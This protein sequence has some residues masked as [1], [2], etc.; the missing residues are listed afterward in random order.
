MAQK[1]YSS[2][3]DWARKVIYCELC[4]KMKLDNT[5]K[6]FMRIPEFVWKDEAIRILW[7]FEIQRD[8]QIQKTTRWE[9]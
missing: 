5:T 6:W 8:L 3:L 9:N 4:K 2:L 7:D 1:E